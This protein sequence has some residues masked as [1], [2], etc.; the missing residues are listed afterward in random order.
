MLRPDICECNIFRK[1][2][3]ILI[4]FVCSLRPLQTIYQYDFEIV[5][6][7]NE[8]K[9]FSVRGFFLKWTKRENSKYETLY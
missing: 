2:F 7:I 1:H 3:K 4:C 5:S 8:L 9:E 6:S